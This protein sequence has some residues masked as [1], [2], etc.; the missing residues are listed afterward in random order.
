MGGTVLY[1][2]RRDTQLPRLL[3]NGLLHIK[4]T[5][6]WKFFQC[7]IVYFH[8]KSLCKQCGALKDTKGMAETAW[9][10]GHNVLYYYI[11]GPAKR[12]CL[13]CRFFL[14]ASVLYSKVIK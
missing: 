10:T 14:P 4:T 12:N 6:K 2:C 8:M 7:W 5:T 3:N 9:Q 1:R 11:T 13:Q